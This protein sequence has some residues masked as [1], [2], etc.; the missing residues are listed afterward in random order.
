MIGIGKAD[1]EYADSVID[2]IQKGKY[3]FESYEDHFWDNDYSD[4]YLDDCYSPPCPK[5]LEYIRLKL[6]ERRGVTK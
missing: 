1:Q 5:I 2:D 3:S 4:S 6:G